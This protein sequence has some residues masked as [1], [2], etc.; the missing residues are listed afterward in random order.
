MATS[1]LRGNDLRKIG[2]PEGRATTLALNIL[3]DRQLKTLDKGSALAL[4]Q[5]IKADPYAYLRDSL[6]R[7]WPRSLCPT[8]GAT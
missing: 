4:L 7:G 1:K 5:K 2:F 6:W 8:P 3:E